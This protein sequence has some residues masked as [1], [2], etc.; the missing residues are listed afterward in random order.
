MVREDGDDVAEAD[1]REM[2]MEVEVTRLRIE[3]SFMLVSGAGVLRVE[4]M[5]EVVNTRG[6]V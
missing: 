6:W 1:E 4:R 5:S 3:V 2:E